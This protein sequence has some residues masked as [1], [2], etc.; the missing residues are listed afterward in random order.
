MDSRL[1]QSATDAADNLF[2]AMTILVHL[3]GMMLLN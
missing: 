1:H 2:K 3:M